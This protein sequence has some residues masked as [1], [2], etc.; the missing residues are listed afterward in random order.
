MLYQRFLVVII[1]R[2]FF[3]Y[4]ASL[5]VIGWIYGYVVGGATICFYYIE[6]SREECYISFRKWHTLKNYYSLVLFPLVVVCYG[7]LWGC[8]LVGLHCTFGW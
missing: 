3:L 1:H 7:A 4:L 2:L 6:V 8:L 5:V